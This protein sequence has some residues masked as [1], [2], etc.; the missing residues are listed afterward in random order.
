[1]GLTKSKRQYDE[2]YFDVL[3]S[4]SKSYW[5]GLL[6]A[7]G[8]I[9]WC[10][11][12]RSYE[13]ALGLSSMDF[14]T[15]DA[16]AKSVGYQKPL[17]QRSRHTSFNGYDYDSTEVAVRLHSK[18]MCQTLINLG[19]VPNKTYCPEFPRGIPYIHAF[20]R[21][22]LDGD[23]C[24][25]VPTNYKKSSVGFTNSNKAFL[26]YLQSVIFNATGVTGS[27]YTEKEWK[28]RLSYWGV[29][30]LLSLLSW[31]YQDDSG[32]KMERKFNK[33]QSLLGL[34]A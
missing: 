7:D 5:L 10:P 34:A 18:H 23:G 11:E 20:V 9:V 2:C 3:D 30:N 26:E 19:V 17:A 22:F 16:F 12:R 33:Y 24:I 27:I 29:A 14:D 1:M 32:W 4:E 15:V 6:F 8:Y 31:I 13:V 21:G 25:T 28:H